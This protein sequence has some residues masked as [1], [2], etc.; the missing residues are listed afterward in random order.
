LDSAFDPSCKPIDERV[1]RA[2]V[3]PSEMPS[4]DQLRVRIDS[5]PS[6]YVAKAKLSAMFLWHVLLFA[7]AELPDFIAL[8]TTASEIADML[9][10]ILLA[11]GPEIVK[12]LENRIF[13]NACH[14]GSRID[15][16]PF[17]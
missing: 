16:H 15:T 4:H 6:P 11:R 10:L 9:A 13:R 14:A 12:Q 1:G 3:A 2:R 17:Y 8:N 7:V 5:D